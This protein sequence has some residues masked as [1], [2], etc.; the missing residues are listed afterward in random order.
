MQLR[1]DSFLTKDVALKKRFPPQ[2]AVL[3]VN[4]GRA[5]SQ[6]LSQKVYLCPNSLSQRIC[7]LL[8]AFQEKAINK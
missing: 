1:T 3:R 8:K 7:C 6:I 5:P 2:A 4:R